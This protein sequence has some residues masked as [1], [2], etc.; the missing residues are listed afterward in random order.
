M[1]NTKIRKTPVRA[2]KAYSSHNYRS[3][4]QVS[5]LS[6]EQKRDIEI[7]SSVLPFKVNNYVVEELINWNNVPYDPMYVLTFPQKDM[8]LPH[9]YSMMKTL[10]DMDADKDKIRETA[11]KIR[12]LLNPHPAGQMELNVPEIHLF[13]VI[14]HSAEGFCSAPS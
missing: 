11:N 7:V 12:I 13:A 8:L 10:Y 3:I 14:V 5:K 9:H 2:Y 6:E 1:K 4:Y